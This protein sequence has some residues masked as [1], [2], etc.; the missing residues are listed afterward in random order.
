MAGNRA[1]IFETVPAQ[2]GTRICRKLNP[3]KGLS[4]ERLLWW[5]T[6]GNTNSANPP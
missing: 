5:Q 1:R 4:D 6:E 3:A 2:L